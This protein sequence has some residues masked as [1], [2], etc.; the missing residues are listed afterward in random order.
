MLG[1]YQDSRPEKQGGRPRVKLSLKDLYIFAVYLMMAMPFPQTI[2]ALTGGFAWPKYWWGGA[3]PESDWTWSY[4]ETNNTVTG[5]RWYLFMVLQSRVL[6][7][8]F[9][10]LNIP[11]WGQLIIVSSTEWLFYIVRWIAG[12]FNHDI[13]PV[14]QFLNVCSAETAEGEKLFP[15]WIRYIGAWIFGSGRSDGCAMYWR[16]VWWYV[17]FYVF[18][19][20]YLRPIVEKTKNILASLKMTGPVWGMAATATSMIIGMWMALYYYP[21]PAL[22]TGEVTSLPGAT[23][24]LLVAFLQPALF[25][26]GTAYWSIDA[27]W[28]GTTTLGCYLVHFY[29]RDQVSSLFMAA[30]KWLSWD[31]TG[32]L[33]PIFILIVCAGFTTTIGPLGHR[34]LIA[35]Q[36]IY[37]RKMQAAAKLAPKAAAKDKA[38]PLIPTD[39]AGDVQMTEVTQVS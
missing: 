4:M 36:M 33:L 22:E 14:Y 7:Q 30:G 21:N 26:L 3:A 11:G 15:V 12:M 9:E 25:S 1:A 39:G 5:H 20:H 38:Q 8:I 24:V 32:V 31:A 13:S 2:K 17:I 27:A 16:W 18:C 6:L 35:P 34:I 29:I 28:W 23:L 10:K 19:F 37:S